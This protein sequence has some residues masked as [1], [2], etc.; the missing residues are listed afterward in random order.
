MK[1]RLLAVS[2]AIYCA[3]YCWLYSYYNQNNQI[4]Q[5]CCQI[6]CDGDT[7]SRLMENVIDL[8]FFSVLHNEHYQVDPN[9]IMLF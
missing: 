3:L 9:S 6:G 7:N 5:L 4:G 8:S 1:C 2:V